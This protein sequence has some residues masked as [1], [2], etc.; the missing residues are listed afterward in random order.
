M[1]EDQCQGELLY[2]EKWFLSYIYVVAALQ[3]KDDYLGKGPSNQKIW[4]LVQNYI[5]LS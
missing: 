3:A 2:L 1:T 5:A 4:M